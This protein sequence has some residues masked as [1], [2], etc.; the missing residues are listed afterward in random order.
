VL[1]FGNVNVKQGKPCNFVGS[2]ER[3]RLRA[4]ATIATHFALLLFA[5]N[6]NA[7]P[8]TQP[9]GNHPPEWVSDYSDERNVRVGESIDIQIGVRDEDKDAITFDATGMPEGMKLTLENGTSDRPIAVLRWRPKNGDVGSHEITI[10]ASDGK[11]SIAKTVKISV[12][13]NWQSYLMPGLQ[14]SM[15][16]PTDRAAL[17]VF[18]GAGAE[19]LFA[20]WIH[21]NENRGPSHGRVYLDMDVLKSNRSELGAMFDLSLGFDLSIERNPV[22]RFLLPYFGLKVGGLIQKEAP[23]GG[24]MQITPLL[25]LY[26]YADRNIFIN[27]SCGYL[28]PVNGEAF[29]AMRGLRGTLGANF[30]L[31]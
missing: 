5:S 22:R 15:Y 16:V 17:G 27:A 12:E 2:L 9:S 11:A 30:S 24:F 8:Q 1:F 4:T 23:K 14:Y 7:S 3:T 26:V 31:W 10:T 20:S 28:L 19:I 6:A 13:D 21:R 18:Q 29:D 25:G